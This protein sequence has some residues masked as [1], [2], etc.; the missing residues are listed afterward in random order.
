MN[1]DKSSKESGSYARRQF[2]AL[3]LMVALSGLPLALRLILN[4]T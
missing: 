1:A 2:A 4:I 3:L